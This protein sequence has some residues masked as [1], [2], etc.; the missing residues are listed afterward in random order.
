MSTQ[1]HKKLLDQVR[2]LLRLKHYSIHTERTYCDWIA[3]Y[4]RYHGMKSR[5]E[6]EDGEKKIEAFLTHLA[7]NEQVAPAT[8]N[9]AMNALVFLYKQVLK[10]PLK[11]T[12]NAVRARKRLNLPVVLTREEV[13]H[14]MDVMQGVPQLVVKILYGC[15]LRI[16]EAVRLRVKDIDYNMLQITVRKG[17]GDKDRITTFPKS[18]I[19]ML[20][21]H[22]AKV[23]QMH[24]MDLKDGYGSAYLPNALARKYARQQ[25]EWHWQYVF[26][27]SRL[28]TDPRSGTVRRHHIDPGSVNKA[29]KRAVKQTGIPKKV[30]AHTFRHSFATHLL[31][32]GTDIRTIQALLGHSDVATTMIYTHVLQQGGQG[33]PSPLD[34][35]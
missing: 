9:Q 11:A 28:S 23:R 24:E 19:P 4:V 34:D 22:L 5:Q 1:T 13:K 32:R 15:G 10:T 21:N 18:V 26:P 31:E 6:L 27:S 16:S 8:Q 20:E 7:V 25:Y 30:S 17:K 35:L 12:I 2:D 3:R 33:V 29:I 14:V